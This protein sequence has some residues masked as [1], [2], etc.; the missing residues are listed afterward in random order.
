[1]AQDSARGSKTPR[2]VSAE[3]AA[4]IVKSGD[5]VD[6]GAAMGQP[7]AFDKA[8]AARRDELEGV[9]IRS[10][11]SLR[12]R[13]V[14]E[15]DPTGR[16]FQHYNWHFG[17]YDRKKC[18][19]GLVTYVPVNLGEISDYY[20]R[21]LEPLDVAAIKVPPKDKDGFYNF[22]CGHLWHRPVIDRAKIVIVEVNENMPYCHGVEA[23]VHESEVD[24]VIEGDGAPLAELPSAP[25][26]AVDKAVGAL[27]A[28][29]IEDG[30]CIQVGIG[31]MPNAVVSSLLE[32]GVKDLGIH[33]EMLTDSMADLVASGQATG[34]RKQIDRGQ[35]V[36][37][38]ALG[39]QKLYDFLDD[40]S[41]FSIRECD[42]TNLPHNAMRNDKLVAI[43]NTT[44]IDLMGQAASESDG[45]RQLTG[46]GGQLQFVRAA[47][48]SKGGKS[49]I[50]LSS[51]YEKGDVRKS[52][53]V[54]CLTPGNTVTTT[55]MDMHYVVTEYGMVCLKGK[56]L[57]ERAKALISIA[58]PDFRE[59]LEREAR[60]NGLVPKW[61]A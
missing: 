2:M 13:E 20:R 12:P 25:P 51:V 11:I 37:S 15:V 58:H 59:D 36:Y 8:L 46:T 54:A 56:S 60:E 4:A 5:W 45:F 61:F 33:T 21:Y 30:A 31:G 29:E 1:M 34:A 41:A 16:H 53:I 40:N 47:Y 9:K 52:R 19:A 27:I 42:Y 49:F 26:S 18:D 28:A 17:G 38:F 57:A 7:D 55:R 39:S 14:M 44:Q 6:Y 35:H 24:F 43:N 50:C 23:G 48:A 22:S 10:C 3:E 32:A